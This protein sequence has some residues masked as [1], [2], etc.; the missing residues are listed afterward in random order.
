MT[1]KTL[2]SFGDE[3]YFKDLAVVI[4]QL[5]ARSIG[6]GSSGNTFVTGWIE[7][8]D[9]SRRCYTFGTFGIRDRCRTD[10]AFEQD[11]IHCGSGNTQAISGARVGVRG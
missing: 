2:T 1:N 7:E 4:G 5:E 8:N 10:G 11:S 9:Y 3:L 6:V